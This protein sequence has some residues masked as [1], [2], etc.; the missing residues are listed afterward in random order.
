MKKKHGKTQIDE[1]TCETMMPGGNPPACWKQS[2]QH[3]CM[4]FGWAR[5]EIIDISS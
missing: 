2:G 4:T 5:T 1:S 3:I